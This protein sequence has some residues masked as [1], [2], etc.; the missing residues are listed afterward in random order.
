M[1]WVAHATARQRPPAAP[2]LSFVAP[3]P[4][5][6]RMPSSDVPVI[7]YE[8][9]PL[10][11][12]HPEARLGF[13]YALLA[14]VA[15]GMFPL[16]FKRVAGVPALEVL[17][18]RVVWSVLF[19]ILLLT[20]TR[21][22]GDV[23]SAL[24]SRHTLLTLVAS[25][26]MIAIN[27]FVFIHAIASNQVLQSS[28]GYYINPLVS[29]LLGVVFLKERLRPL[30]LTGLALAVCGVANLAWHGILPWI[31]LVLAISFGMYGLI[32]KTTPAGP[33]VGLAVET[34]ILFVPAVLIIG[35]NLWPATTA[36]DGR[37][38]GWLMFAGVLTTVPLLWFA[39]AARRLRLSTMGFLQ[40]LTP[41]CQFLLA[42]LVF[43]EPFTR[44]HL[45]TFAIIWLAL[46]AYSVDSYRALRR[47]DQRPV[48]PAAA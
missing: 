43:K 41:S 46:V 38:Y 35:R 40:Y 21:R 12:H 45:V 16:Y 26:A 1:G 18:H 25:T 17:S 47:M 2:A 36:Y 4:Y 37:T 27:W 15:W 13:V 11:G 9:P 42:V 28:L 32:R 33:M 24:S 44:T 3:G 29:V 8:T 48:V 22:W 39:G 7:P 30:Q 34:A 19:L 14:Y 5:N 10:R 6:I 23:R 20:V 31:S